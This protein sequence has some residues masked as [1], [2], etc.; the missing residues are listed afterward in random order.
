MCHF[1]CNCAETCSEI[2]PPSLP[3]LQLKGRPNHVTYSHV[4]FGH[5][6]IFILLLL[7]LCIL[8][9]CMTVINWCCLIANK[10][11]FFPFNENTMYT[12][13]RFVEKLV[14][15]IG[16]LYRPG[17][18]ISISLF[19]SLF[20]F[21]YLFYFFLLTVSMP[22][23]HMCCFSHSDVTTCVN[24]MVLGIRLRCGPMFHSMFLIL[25]SQNALWIV[26]R[27]KKIYMCMC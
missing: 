23:F 15:C 26:K 18:T 20:N 22:I 21:F 25:C 19:L 4:I 8:S 7:L 9:A 3:P 16:K 10:C 5:W 1:N 6:I 14:I 2:P 13:T 12:H 24:T 27:T 17:F 11:C